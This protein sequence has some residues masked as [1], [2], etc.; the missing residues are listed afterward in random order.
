MRADSFAEIALQGSMPAALAVALLAGLVSFASPCVLPLVPGYLGYVTGLSGVDLAKR[1]RGR[2]VA[3]AVLFVVGFTIV[4]VAT[5]ST[6]SGVVGRLVAHQDTVTQVAGAVV[7]ALGLLFIGWVPG[8]HRRWQSSWRPSAGLAGAPLLGAVFAVGWTPCIGPTLST[9]LFL[10]T[11]EGGGFRR[12]VVLA[13]A[14]CLG[15]G[16]PFVLV[17]LGWSRASRVLGALRRHQRELQVLGGLMLVAVGVLM[18]TGV[19]TTLISRLATVIAGFG[20]LV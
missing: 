8:G 6:L 5:T 19:W 7:V 2:M 14:Y 17:A 18:L 9:V 3:G 12:G 10:T 20:V 1:R 15:L 11:S 13:V 16:V 4:F